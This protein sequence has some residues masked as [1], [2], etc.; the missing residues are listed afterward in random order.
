[1][2]YFFDD[3]NENIKRLESNNKNLAEPIEQN[4]KFKLEIENQFRMLICNLIITK[5]D[6]SFVVQVTSQFVFYPLLGI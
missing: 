2:A 6:V 3:G 1:M 4:L 5:F